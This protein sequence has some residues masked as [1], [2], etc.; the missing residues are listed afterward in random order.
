MDMRADG[1]T[2]PPTKR[3]K[4]AELVTSYFPSASASTPTINKTPA[5]PPEILLQ[6]IQHLDHNDKQTLAR[7]MRVSP[8]FNALVA[9]KLYHTVTIEGQTSDEG[10]DRVGVFDIPVKKARRKS[11]KKR[12]VKSKKARNVKVQGKKEDLKHVRHV[13]F[14]NSFDPSEFTVGSIDPSQIVSV[15]MHYTANPLDESNQHI[16]PILSKFTGLEKLV[17]TGNY[18]W[19][20]PKLNRVSNTCTKIVSFI[21]SGFPSFQDHL[22]MLD[23]KGLET[24]VY[25]V[26]DMSNSSLW[27]GDVQGPD[28]VPLLIL[29]TR[30]LKTRQTVII[31]NAPVMHLAGG[32]IEETFESWVTRLLDGMFKQMEANV[33]KDPTRLYPVAKFMSMF[34]YLRDYEHAGEFTEEEMGWVMEQDVKEKQTKGTDASLGH[35]TNE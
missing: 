31:V 23:H 5:I 29:L 25:I 28:V 17:V 18:F 24:F 26:G 13:Y 6:I 19:D 20:L 9:P 15:R 10:S 1:Q 3:A 11:K 33:Q 32:R 30:E 8:V 34:E 12:N 2:P 4:R 27:T 16:P 14:A 7:C 21:R 22:G 35:G